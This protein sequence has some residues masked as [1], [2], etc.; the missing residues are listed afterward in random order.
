MS[1]GGERRNEEN[2]NKQNR[3]MKGRM[4]RK[5]ESSAFGKRKGNG[6]LV[7]TKRIKRK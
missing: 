4:G 3:M 7:K 2:I 6:R 1:K 5:R